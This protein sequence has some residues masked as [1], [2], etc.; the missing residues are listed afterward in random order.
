MSV[1]VAIDYG[2][3]GGIGIGEVV[4]NAGHHLAGGAGQAARLLHATAPHTLH[5]L[6][7]LVLLL[8]L[9]YVVRHIITL[10]PG[11][12]SPSPAVAGGG[13]RGAGVGVP[14]AAPLSVLMNALVSAGRMHGGHFDGLH[15]LLRGG[16]VFVLLPL[17]HAQH[18]QHVVR[19]RHLAALSSLLLLRLPE[20]LRYYCFATTFVD[21]F[22][23]LEQIKVCLR[24]VHELGHGETVLLP[25]LVAV[26]Q[27]LDVA[28]VVELVFLG[29]LAVVEVHG[30]HQAQHAA[31]HVQ[32]QR[33]S[34]R[35]VEEEEEVCTHH[36]VVEGQEA[37][38]RA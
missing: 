23:G 9:P 28:I 2:H 37:P 7:T 26:E 24:P 22:E 33:A 12:C 32:R 35:L 25:E 27:V 18:Y 36:V 16:F 29:G 1:G 11:R 13:G 21:H 15:T 30:A 3:P 20:L 14:L 5:L 31:S 34:V 38:Q 10:R 6:Q 19:I 17:S 8:A 4:D